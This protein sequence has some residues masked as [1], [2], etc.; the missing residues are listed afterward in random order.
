MVA[1]AKL[2]LHSAV[3]VHEQISEALRQEVTRQKPGS[4]LPTETELMARFQVSRTTVRRAVQ[5][6]V[7]EGLLLRR[8]GKGTFVG[9]KRPVQIVDRLAPFVESFTASGLS[10]VASLLQY[11]WIS[12]T[13]GLPEAL[14]A[15]GGDVL[16]LRRLYHA[17]GLPM[18]VAEI[19][20]P[21]RI[22]RVISRADIEEHPVY[23]VLQERA[24]RQPHH[25]EIL[26]TFG[27]AD[28]DTRRLLE[29]DEGSQV[30][31]LQRTTYDSAGELLECMVASLRPEAFELRTVV[32]AD[33]PIPVSY[34]FGKGT[35]SRQRAPN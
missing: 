35:E 10:P 32:T 11:S 34:S 3:A 19:Y 16:W 23:W 30:P 31:R 29:L 17:D 12:D 21:E 2:E 24:Q 5:T 13:R 28:E 1:T 33:Q 20:V 18:A 9:A 7:D 25:A 4:R 14:A 27:R 6:L 22:G 15:V 8:Q 26:L